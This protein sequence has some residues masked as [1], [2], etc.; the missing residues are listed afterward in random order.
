MPVQHIYEHVYKPLTGHLP[1]EKA[2]IL[3]QAR[4]DEWV[5]YFHQTV[6]FSLTLEERSEQKYVANG[7]RK[8]IPL[9]VQSR[10]TVEPDHIRDLI[11]MVLL[12]FDG[13]RDEIIKMNNW[14]PK[15]GNKSKTPSQF[16]YYFE[17]SVKDLREGRLKVVNNGI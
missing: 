14:H 10:I 12:A 3:D 8:L 2:R 1:H 13:L 4:Q 6:D 15:S 7:L 16:Q 5:E 9:M 17:A 11:V